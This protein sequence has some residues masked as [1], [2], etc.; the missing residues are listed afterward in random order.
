MRSDEHCLAIIQLCLERSF[1]ILVS[2]KQDDVVIDTIF[3]K[4]AIR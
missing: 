2:Q 1:N 4:D 3:Q